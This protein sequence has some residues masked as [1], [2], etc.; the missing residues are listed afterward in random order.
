MQ[1][2]IKFSHLGAEYLACP[3]REQQHT[4]RCIKHRGG[5]AGVIQADSLKELLPSIAGSRL[6][7]GP[8]PIYEAFIWAGIVVVAVL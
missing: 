7:A 1:P 6:V 3:T 2:T 8:I 5:D 4:A